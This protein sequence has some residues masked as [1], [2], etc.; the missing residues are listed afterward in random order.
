M[1][2]CSR[3][4]TT[5]L[6]SA[7]ASALALNTATLGIG[8]AGAEPPS[9]W[10]EPQSDIQLQ[11]YEGMITDTQC[12]AKHSVAIGKMAADCTVACVRGGGQFALVDGDIT[13][14]LEGDPVT[15]NR[16]AGQRVRI[17]G[18]LNGRKISVTSVV[19]A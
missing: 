13:Y 12:G 14:L 17:V 5:V 6:V 7:I 19:T 15:L 9:G 11:T 3:I 4:K 16:V 8:E 18:A 1:K 10:P 2:T